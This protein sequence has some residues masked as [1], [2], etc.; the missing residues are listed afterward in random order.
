MH[1]P[2]I[3]I[4]VV[5]SNPH[6]TD[7]LRL[8]TEERVIRESVALSQYRKNISLTTCPA[9]TIHDLSRA[10]LN[11]TFQVIQIS[12]HGSGSGL[13][14]ENEQGGQYLVHEPILAELFQEYSSSI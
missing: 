6:G 4:L 5:F 2:I 9:A 13:I 10:L 11:G 14:L 1:R 7:T 8:H 12:G 3:N